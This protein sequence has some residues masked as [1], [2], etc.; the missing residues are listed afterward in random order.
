VSTLEEALEHHQAGRLGEAEHIYRAILRSQPHH[1]DASHLLGV[2]AAQR[3]Q[4]ERAVELIENAIR[5]DPTVAA[6]HS[7][8]GKALR[9]QDLHDAATSA[10]RR[11]LALRFDNDTLADLSRSLF[12][13]GQAEQAVE[14]YLRTLDIR[15]KDARARK[16]LVFLLR[17]VRPTGVWVELEQELS[18]CYRS[19]DIDHQQLAGITANQLKYKYE[20]PERLP[21]TQAENSA[22]LDALASD[23]LL[24]AL[25]AQTVN[26]D[27]ELERFLTELRRSFL[28]MYHQAARLPKAHIALIGAL[29]KQCFNNEY[30][31]NADTE[32]ARAVELLKITVCAH[33]IDDKES[34]QP[35]LE[36][37]LLLLACYV[38]I[39]SL[40]CAPRLASLNIKR[41]HPVLQALIERTL[42]EP[43]QEQAIERSIE[44]L[45]EIDD[46]TSRAVRAQYEENPYPR[47]V[48]IGQ[49]DKNDLTSMLRAQFPHFRPPD[50]LNESVRILV[51]GCG[52]GKE[53][54]SFALTYQKAAVVA[55]DLSRR[56]L[57]Y[58]TRMARKIGVTNVRFLQADILNLEQLGEHFH[59]ISSAGVLHHLADPLAGWRVLAERL[60]P[61]GLMQVTLYSES[62]RR[63]LTVAQ[64]EIKRR[65]LKPIAEDIRSFRTLVLSGAINGE[66]ADLTV[67][68][69]FYSLSSCRDLL[70]HVKEHRFTVAQIREALA[71]LDLALIGFDLRNLQIQQ[72]YYEC[73]RRHRDI[74]DFTV[75]EQL[76]Q[77]YPQAF[78][79]MYRFWCQKT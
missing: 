4:P 42:V 5:L 1:P 58:A 69:D 43:L 15:P 52:T 34:L 26:V 6:Y 19:D 10:F 46:P 7:N 71:A 70:F 8:L 73:S 50:F 32:E 16:E 2:V 56:S 60:V 36:N 47:W 49:S 68:N 64:E 45:G 27:Y 48:S 67:G 20:L 29:A 65:G 54:I 78:L 66:L 9:A 79:S 18:T 53:P 17:T 28:L 74:A 21:L 75:C 31:F 41:W 23:Q 13:Q 61:S 55:V 30:V 37:Q 63:P 39:E 72:R 14:A 38:S 62:A 40:H 59:V 76:E 11:A 33:F 57:A 12:A 24:L 44:S 25:L 22:F 35:E 3:A 77:R 51:A